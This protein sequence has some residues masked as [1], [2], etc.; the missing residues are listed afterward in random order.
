MDRYE[1]CEVCGERFHNEYIKRYTTETIVGDE[2]NFKV[3]THCKSCKPKK[4][5][6]GE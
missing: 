6:G 2:N 4:S 3:I 1:D 5:K